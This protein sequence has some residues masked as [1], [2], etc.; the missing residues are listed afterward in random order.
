VQERGTIAPRGLDLAAVR[1][2][3]EADSVSHRLV[4]GGHV[5]IVKRKAMPVHLAELRAETRVML[6]QEKSDRH[7]FTTS[8]CLASD[9]TRAVRSPRGWGCLGTT[10]RRM[11]RAME[12]QAEGRVALALARRSVE[13]YVTA[14]VLAEPPPE[15]PPTLHERAGA[16]VSLRTDGQLRGCVGTLDA[17]QASLAHEIMASAIGAATRDPRF[18]PV[19][20]VELPLLI[21]EVD[22][23]GHL[24]TVRATSDLD[25]RLYGI[26]VEAEGRRGVLLPD[27]VGVDDAQHQLAIARAKAGLGPDVPVELCRFRVRR[28]VERS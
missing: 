19:T 2:V 21:Y 10:L 27:L 25:P 6:V 17:T 26:V 7:G 20:I 3:D 8:G 1:S 23:V 24:E 5:P 4:L 13:E 11:M 15:L 9:Y 12:T 18:F 16:F 22:V 14:G 28:H